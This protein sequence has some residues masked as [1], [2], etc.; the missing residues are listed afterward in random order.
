MFHDLFRT[1]FCWGPVFDPWLGGLNVQ[2]P[3]ELS[4]LKVKHA[5]L[6]N[7][8]AVFAAELHDVKA[9]LEQSTAAKVQLE[10]TSKA[11]LDDVK[12]KLEQTTAAKAKLE[13][14]SKAELDDVKAKLEQT[15]AAKAQLEQASKAELDD[16]KA[17]LEQ[18]TAAKAQLE[19]AS[20]AE[21][22]DVKAKLEQTTAAKA[23]LEQASKAELD[24]VKAKL[25]QTTAAKAQLEQTSKA[26]LDDVKAKLEQTTAAKA[27]LEQA[28]KAELDDVKAKL[29][30]TTAAKAQL[31]QASK[32]ELDDDKAKLEQATAAKAQLEQASKAELGGV[33]AKLEQTIAA[34]MQLEQTPEDFRAKF[35]Q[36]WPANLATELTQWYACLPVGTGMLAAIAFV[37]YFVEMLAKLV[38]NDRRGDGFGCLLD[39]AQ[40]RMIGS[41]ASCRN[42]GLVEVNCVSTALLPS[43][44]HPGFPVETVVEDDLKVIAVHCPGV[45]IHDV[46]VEYYDGV[47]Q[48]KVQIDRKEAK[49]VPPLQ[50]EWNFQFDTHHEF[51]QSETRPAFFFYLSCWF[52]WKTAFVLNLASFFVPSK[53]CSSP[54]LVE[55]GASVSLLW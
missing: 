48:G 15:T 6:E 26:E 52:E 44:G 12:A 14:A 53:P 32:A 45:T 46:R 50:W 33:K 42:E 2:C 9:K 5:A 30:Q 17:K 31:E 4:D 1:Q 27:Q 13:Q 10:Q 22:D 20:K 7:L 35:D 8:S 21:L 37:S 25:E 49:G 18:T 34:K 39:P 3:T 41:I 16:V 11:E 40:V 38:K 54:F 47:S 23:Q 24:D 28:S 36:A 19:Q 51:V 43:A 29:E 55:T